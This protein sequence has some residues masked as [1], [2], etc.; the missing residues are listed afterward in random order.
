MI[1]FMFKNNNSIVQRINVQIYNKKIVL[2][3]FNQKKKRESLNIIKIRV[4]M[5]N[6]RKL[7]MPK[8]IEYEIMNHNYRNQYNKINI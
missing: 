3:V 2:W 7:K 8:M 5:F 6:S 1:E 4:L